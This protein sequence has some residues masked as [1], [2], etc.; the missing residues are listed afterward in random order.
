MCIIENVFR[1]EE[2]NLQII[3]YED[4]IWIKAVAVATILSYKNTMK[5]IRDHVDSEDKRKLLELGPKSKWNET[6]PVKRMRKTQFY[7]RVWS[8]QFN[9]SL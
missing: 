3:K 7:Q 5:S 8:I 6:F 4:E 1:Y 9:T 2:T